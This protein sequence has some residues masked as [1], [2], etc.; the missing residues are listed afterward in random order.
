MDDGDKGFEDQKEVS[1]CTDYRSK[2]APKFSNNNIKILR[3]VFFFPTNSNG[4]HIKSVPC[5]DYYDT[6]QTKLHNFSLKEMS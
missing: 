3:N 1:C 4:V 6:M 2:G 5:S